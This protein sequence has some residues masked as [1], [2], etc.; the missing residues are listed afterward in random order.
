M[1][2]R[3][4]EYNY[5]ARAPREKGTLNVG[6]PVFARVF[7][8]LSVKSH[9]SGSHGVLTHERRRDQTAHRIWLAWI[10]L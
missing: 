2:D 6:S 3:L 4:T 10:L 1:M 9:L 7:L 8:D 5:N